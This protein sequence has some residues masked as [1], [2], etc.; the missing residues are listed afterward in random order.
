MAL[1][2]DQ[3]VGFME[4]YFPAYSQSGQTEQTQHVMDRF[5]APDV[6][7]DDGLITSREQW[8]KACLSHPDIQD[9]IT[10]EHLFVDEKQQEAGALVRTQAIQRAT[11]KILVE[12]KMNAFYSLR[13]DNNNEIKISHIKVFLES[14]PQ[15]AAKLMQIYGMK[16]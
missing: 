6:A 3:I 8:Y 2:Y 9:K 10:L 5:Y 13:V 11:G 1:T 16:M 14:N 7:F 4:E 12:I 15:K